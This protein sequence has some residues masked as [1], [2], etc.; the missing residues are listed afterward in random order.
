LIIM[1][2]FDCVIRNGTIADGSGD[3]LREADIAI[4]D[5]RIAAIGTDLPRGSEEIDAR[6]LLVTPGFVDIHTHYDG[7]VTWEDTLLPSSDH[8]VTTV[9]MGN[10]GVGF[11]PCRKQDRKALITLMEGVEDLPEAVLAAGI[12][13][14]W[15]DFGGYLDFLAGRAYNI[16]IAAQIPHA[17]VRV[18]AMGERAFDREPATE[19]DNARMAAIVGE[20]IR[21][22]AF[23]FS[24]SRSI[25]HKGSDGRVT[26]SLRAA[27]AEL[28]AIGRAVGQCGTGVLQAIS[29]LDDP[30]TELAMLERVCRA[31]GR[32]MSISLLQRKAAPHIWRD[33]LRW[34]ER[35]NAEGLTVRAQVSERPVGSLLGLDLSINP[36]SRAPA[37]AELAQLP[38][39]DRAR[40]L[41]DPARKR[42]IIAQLEEQNM[43]SSFD[44]M[45][46][47]DRQPNYEPGPERFLPA[48][49]AERNMRPI[50]LL[51]DLLVADEG[52]AIVA[53]HSSNYEEGSLDVCHEM[54]VHP[55]TV[56]G[57][58]DGG[59]HLGIL[60]DSSQPT[61]LLS[62][63][64]RD[65][66]KDR[67]S[68]GQAVSALTREP[69]ETVGLGDRGRLAP[70]LRADI[71]VIDYD[72]LSF[73]RPSV[74]YDLPHG[75]R[76]LRQ[77]SHG[78]VATLV[79]GTRIV[80]HDQDTGA[81]PGRLVRGMH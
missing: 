78:Y 48:M 77:R 21:K 8:G 72:K 64:T 27:E 17:P 44:R 12:P 4:R 73:E 63:W 22:G 71:N 56:I 38:L 14:E 54:M 49:A 46:V 67:L 34:I 9:L 19:D 69:A 62:Y 13:W 39:A 57:L 24:T 50:E 60:C 58:A 59:A 23:G 7:Q 36:I 55:N 15:E 75:G 11:A 79:G 26:P 43:I 5:G 30:E 47:M 28:T 41:A 76:R 80:D 45:F 18:Y 20:A 53:Q 37:Y 61:H 10:C 42:K 16:D 68:I 33:V 52:H 35:M 74:T 51:Y 3:E 66:G 2:D 25:N 70:G 32:P 31:S 6:G 65:R 40:A 1:A 81:R 29:D